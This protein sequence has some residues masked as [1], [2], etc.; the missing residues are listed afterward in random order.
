M[1]MTVA[2][3]IP[4]A[5]I[6]VCER[7]E[8]DFLLIK[9]ALQMNCIGKYL[10]DSVL[11]FPPHF[12]PQTDRTD[13]THLSLCLKNLDC[14]YVIHTMYVCIQTVYLSESKRLSVCV[15]VQIL[16]FASFVRQFK[17]NYRCTFCWCLA[18]I[19]SV[20]TFYTQTL[21]NT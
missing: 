14:I 8:Y 16:L 11:L 19:S 20:Y 3:Y 9:Y 5:G 18:I 15:R 13:Q 10:V 2:L 4:I 7:A 21:K 1:A 12:F 6:G 17:L